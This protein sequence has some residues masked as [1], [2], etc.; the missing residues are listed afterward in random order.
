MKKSI[1]SLQ[2]KIFLFSPLPTPPLPHSLLPYSLL[3]YK[4]YLKGDR[5][6]RKKVSDRYSHTSLI[7]EKIRDKINP[8]F[9][10]AREVK[11]SNSVTRNARLQNRT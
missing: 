8:L 2:Q 1:L 7:R 4:K 3:P 5:S 11:L 6:Y 9:P 10:I